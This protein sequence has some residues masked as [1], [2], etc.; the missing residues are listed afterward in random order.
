MGATDDRSDL[1]AAL[2]SPGVDIVEE[3]A[4]R[5]DEVP[6]NGGSGKGR[7]TKDAEGI[8][9]ENQ[10][11][12]KARLSDPSTK[13][14]TKQLAVLKDWQKQQTVM[15]A[16]CCAVP[17]ESVALA[18]LGSGMSLTGHSGVRQENAELK[19]ATEKKASK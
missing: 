6:A 4:R 14:G 2:N 17:T 1:A 9:G 18:L 5:A 3:L 19:K 8:A 13:K 15:I 16:N 12:M 10:T 7:L 11:E